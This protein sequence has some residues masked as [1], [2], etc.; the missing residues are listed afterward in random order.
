MKKYIGGLKMH[1]N[2][3]SNSN[4]SRYSV[5][6][7]GEHEIRKLVVPEYLDSFFKPGEVQEIW[8]GKLFGQKFTYGLKLNN[9]KVRKNGLGKSFFS[10][11]LAI[12]VLLGMMV[13]PQTVYNF[14][15]QVSLKNLC[16]FIILGLMGVV[17]F[18]Q[19]KN[20]INYASIK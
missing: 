13:I 20:V 17:V 11:I 18:R 5:V 10:S 3:I 15:G 8:I 16:I 7:I 2:G 19:I 12:I 9:G 4:G 14:T 1:G 6:E